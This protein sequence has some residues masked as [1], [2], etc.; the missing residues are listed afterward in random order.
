MRPSTSPEVTRVEMVR[1]A[2][3]A[4]AR[5]P[6]SEPGADLP[7]PLSDEVV[8]TTGIAPASRGRQPRGLT[9][10][11]RLDEYGLSARDRT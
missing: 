4:P 2:G 5:S 8:K 6:G 10:C 1:K 11:L 3:I 7:P 9:R